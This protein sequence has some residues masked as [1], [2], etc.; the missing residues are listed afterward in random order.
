MLRADYLSL[1]FLYVYCD[2]INKAVGVVNK[3]DETP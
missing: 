2:N 1:V 3:Y